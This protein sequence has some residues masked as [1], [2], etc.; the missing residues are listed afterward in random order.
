MELLTLALGLGAGAAATAGAAALREHRTQ[1]AGLAD[2]L[3]YAFL[4]DEAGEEAGGAVLLQKDG[5][6]LTAWRYRGPDLAAATAAELDLLSVRM[7]AALLPLGDGWMLHFDAVRRPASGYAPPGAFPDPVTRLID[8]ERRRAHQTGQ[9]HYETECFCALTYLPPPDLYARLARH[10]LDGRSRQ[11]TDWNAI[12]A[13]FRRQARDLERRLSSCL[14]VEPLDADAL[15]THLHVCLTGLHHP[16]RTPAAG[17]QLDAL[18]ADQDLVGG[19]EPRIGEMHLRTIAV[20]GFPAGSCAGMLD[21]LNSLPFAARTSHRLIPLGRQSASR[22]IRRLRQ[23]WFRKRRSLFDWLTG[24]VA[25]GSGTAAQSQ[26][27]QAIDE[28]FTDQDAIGMTRD[29]QQA[30]AANASGAVLF[31][32]YS[33]TIVVT[34]PSPARADFVAGQI[35]QI[36]RDLGFTARIES[37]NALEAWLGSLPG[38][39]YPNLRRP[40]LH[41][42]NLADLLPLTSVWPGPTAVP[43]P[44]FPEASPPLLWAATSGATPFR[45]SLHVS[46]VGH[47]LVVGP[48]GSGKSTFVQLAVAQ[49][50]RY[51]EA[52]VFVFDVGYSGYLLAQAAGARHHA[53]A[54]A[55]PD[56]ISFQP[57]GLLDQPGEIAWAA[58][59]LELALSLQKVAVQPADRTALTE[60]LRLLASDAP[61]HRTLTQLSIQLQAPHLVEAL[62]PLTLAGPVG[63]LLDAGRDDL[64]V[65]PFVVFEIQHL[66]EMDPWVLLPVL[67]YLFHRIEQRLDGRPTLIVIEEAWL[68]LLHSAFADKIRAWLLTLR[69]RNAAVMLVTQSLAQ[70]QA[71]PSAPVLFD[72]CPTRILLPNPAAASPGNRE[73]YQA[74]GL[75]ET[76]IERLAGAT[77]KRQY[78]YRSPRGSRLFELGLGPL[79]LAFLGAAEGMT[80][81]ETIRAADTLRTAHG[82]LWPRAWLLQRGLDSWASLYPPTEGEPT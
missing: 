4:V 68:P 44:Y 48:T 61:E 34:E 17:A 35:L 49:F 39:G 76:E 65:A 69:K 79:A 6:L 5:S 16:V 22:Q 13:D 56:A 71:T 51:P 63:Q 36:L 70:L 72:S 55:A 18:L 25:G 57:L 15:L 10:F 77:P 75:N 30:E 42:L 7:N 66:L 67:T 73:L 74:L 80:L 21:G 31:C 53:I 1:P 58:Q 37:V 60:A 59:W 64:R 41:S 62:R 27:Q 24:A 8:E 40:I 28:L 52:Q 3:L 23:A 33:G 46:D 50:F 29:A 14:D 47:S 12:L 38:H 26:Q 78:Y 81:Q 32:L 11:G 45:L 20:H 82:P 19:W 9:G 2:L 43:S 54:A